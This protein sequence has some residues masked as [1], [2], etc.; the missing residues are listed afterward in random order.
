MY[1]SVCHFRNNGEIRS[2]LRLEADLREDY[3]RFV[4]L[5]YFMPEQIHT[6]Q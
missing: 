3:I 4:C 5:V 6:T 1:R 2:D